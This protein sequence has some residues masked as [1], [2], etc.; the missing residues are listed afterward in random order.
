MQPSR[1]LI[2]A[3]LI[4]LFIS[5]MLSDIH[6]KYISAFLRDFGE[7][8]RLRRPRSPYDVNRHAC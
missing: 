6:N 1:A 7:F 8:I 2:G 3:T 4:F 5:N